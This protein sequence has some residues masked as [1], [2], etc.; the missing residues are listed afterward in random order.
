MVICLSLDR[1]DRRR[2]R[3]LLAENLT[4]TGKWTLCGIIYI[5]RIVCAE[6][7]HG[8]GVDWHH[9]SALHRHLM[10]ISIDTCLTL[11][12]CVNQH[13]IDSWPIVGWVSSDSCM[14]VLFDTQWYISKNYLARPTSSVDRVPV[15]PR[16]QS[17]IN[18]VLIKGINR[19]ALDHG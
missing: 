13:L 2:K 6:N 4:P 3:K 9:H 8:L 16:N 17:S 11:S 19:V 10:D 12:Q 5:F 15:Q 18:Q 7:I 14:Y 1:G